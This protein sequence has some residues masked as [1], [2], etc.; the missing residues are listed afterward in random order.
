MSRLVAPRREW[1]RSVNNSRLDAATS[2]M[3]VISCTDS[4]V[5]G[6]DFE[7]IPTIRMES[8]HSVESSFSCD[9]SSIYIVRELSPSE[10]VSRLGGYKKVF[11][12]KTT[13]CRKS[14]KISFRKD[15]PRRRSTSCV[16]ISWNLADRKSVK[17]CV[18]YLTKQKKIGS[19]SRSRFC[20]DRA[21]NLPGPAQD[22]RSAP[23]F[24]QIRSL[25][26]ELY[27]NAWTSLKRAT[28]C[29]QYSAK[30]QL[31]RRVITLYRR[32]PD[33]L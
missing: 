12:E 4:A 30:L 3:K 17:S 26:A 32:F 33:M 14:L 19:R 1:I 25:P 20:A 11:L 31:L 6:N 2:R 5:Q 23:N 9:F 29:F 15:S 18:I 7:L 24:I 27:S 21:Q 8:G 10:V 16:Q 13:P 28:K 22:T